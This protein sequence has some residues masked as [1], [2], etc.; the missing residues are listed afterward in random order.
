MHAL[1]PRATALTMSLPRRTPPSQITSV[2]SADGVDDGRDELDRR[3]RRVELPAAV[4]RQGDGLDA[5]LGGEHRVGHG[6]DPLDDQ[7]AVPHRAEPVD[8]VPRQV[9]VELR[10]DVRRTA[11]PGRGR[12]RRDRCRSRRARSPRWRTRSGRSA[13]TPTSTRGARRRRAA[14]RGRAWAASR[15]RAGRRARGARAPPCRRSSRAPRSRPPG[16]ARPCP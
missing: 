10:V 11:S 2:R 15:S 5:V 6:L 16:T 1:A 8:V 12:R 3:R 9:G 7:R 14:C 13:R 4:V